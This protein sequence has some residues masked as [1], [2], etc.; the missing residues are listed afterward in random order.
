M[1]PKKQIQNEIKTLIYTNY[2]QIFFNEYGY[3][4][5]TLLQASLERDIYPVE[6]KLRDAMFY[7]D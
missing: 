4:I 5:Y 1:G 7:G 3:D 2:D 6:K